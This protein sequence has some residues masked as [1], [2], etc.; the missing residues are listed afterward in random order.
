[1]KRPRELSLLARLNH[2]LQEYV[3]DTFTV[4]TD[5]VPQW[6]MEILIAD[7]YQLSQK[8]GIDFRDAVK[9]GIELHE[10]RKHCGA[11]DNRKPAKQ[12]TQP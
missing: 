4:T 1:M 3:D 9:W 12:V 8:R 5:C 11:Y 10:E 2:I 7:L 6:G